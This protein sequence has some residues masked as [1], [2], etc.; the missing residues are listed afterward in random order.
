MK[1]HLVLKHNTTKDFKCGLC[2]KEFKRDIELT[3]H[4][5]IHREEKPFACELCEKRF[6]RKS[7]FEIH[8]KYHKTIEKK[9]KCPTCSKV[10]RGP[11]NL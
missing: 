3:N 5:K 1:T 4:E 7:T 10:F 6:A 2:E 9:F 11:E 8:T